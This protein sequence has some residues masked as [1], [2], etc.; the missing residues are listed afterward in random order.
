MN[1]LSRERGNIEHT[2]H[3]MKDP[4]KKKEKKGK[5]MSNTRCRRVIVTGKQLPFRVTHIQVSKSGKILFYLLIVNSISAYIAL[6]RL[7]LFYY[8]ILQ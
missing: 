4:P 2:R 6:S 7:T 8:I 3:G 1:G 5:K